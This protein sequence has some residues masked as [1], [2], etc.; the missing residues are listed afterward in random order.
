MFNSCLS[1]LGGYER[2]VWSIEILA[3]SVLDINYAVIGC[4]LVECS[5]HTFLQSFWIQH[6]CS[7]HSEKGYIQE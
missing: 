1:L 4:F 7:E 2:L 6:V 3:F 5:A